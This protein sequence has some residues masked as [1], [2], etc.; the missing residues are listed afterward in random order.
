MLA[1]SSLVTA[2]YRP[3]KKG[4]W[5]D[6]MREHEQRRERAC[7]RPEVSRT[8]TFGKIGVSKGQFFDKHLKY[9]QLN[10]QPVTYDDQAIKAVLKENYDAPFLHEVY[11]APVT[12]QLELGTV[13]C[14]G[15]TRALLVHRL[16]LA[17]FVGA[18][19]LHAVLIKMRLVAFVLSRS[20]SCSLRGGCPVHTVL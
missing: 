19:L 5:D 1:A 3:S 4:Y 16:C 14:A 9:I 12:T 10:D 11:E 13:S 15:E 17:S 20:A 2:R 18:L 8:R 7:I 6:W